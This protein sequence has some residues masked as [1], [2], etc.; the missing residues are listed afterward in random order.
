MTRLMRWMA[1]AATAAMVLGG[2][3]AFANDST[4]ELAAGG[5]VLTKNTAIQMRSEDLFI[6]DTDVKVH[7]VFANTTAA[8]V[9]VTV[10]F[11]M[12]DI[13]IEGPDDNIS[14]PSQSNPNQDQTNFLGFST[15]ADGK[16]VVAQVEQKA[17]KNG[18]DVTAYLRSLGIPL[19]P[20]LDATN[21]ALSALP[22]A[23]Q[24]ELIK[25]G[26]AM[27]AG[28]T[29]A[30]NTVIALQATW[31]L[32]TTYF[33]ALDLSQPATAIVIDHQVHA[34]GGLQRRHRLGHEPS[35]PRIPTYAQ[36]RAKYCVDDSFLAAVKR[37]IPAGQDFSPLQE[38]RIDYI[39]T[40]GANWAAPI[41]DFRMTIDKG[42]PTR[43]VSFCGTGVQKISP[44]QFQVHYPELCPQERRWGPDPGAPELPVGAAKEPHETLHQQ[45][46]PKPR[47]VRWFMAEKRSTRSGGDR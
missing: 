13:T 34:G 10:A 40:S 20:Q 3:A 9:T 19:A 46:A 2:G 8:D 4:A 38:E 1:G 37:T 45:R 11:P 24:A 42:D 30:N 28:Y 31:T 23:A 35:S 44:T 29:D 26:L 7:Y 6:S 5:L 25:K 27:D 22:K 16:P 18:V 33:W 21:R 12:P 32:K 15:V 39:L 17:V 41:G 14:I 43:L 36:Q 47:R